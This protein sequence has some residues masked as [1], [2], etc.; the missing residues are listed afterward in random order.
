MPGTGVVRSIDQVLGDLGREIAQARDLALSLEQV[1]Q[2]LAPHADA[3][4]LIDCQAADLL[5][6]RLGGL[7]LFVETLARTSGGADLEV[8]AAA[9]ALPLRDQAR[10]LEGE[11]AVVESDGLTWF[12]E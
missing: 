3:L 12:E 8:G 1:L 6:Q 11:F 2:A 5:T 10:R 9:A 7:V 4:Q